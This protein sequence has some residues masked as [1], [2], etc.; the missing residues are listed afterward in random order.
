MVT[1]D[2][3]ILFVGYDHTLDWMIQSPVS[4]DTGDW[5]IQ[6]RSY[7]YNSVDSLALGVWILMIQSFVNLIPT[8]LSLYYKVSFDYISWE[9][10]TI[11][12]INKLLALRLWI[13][14]TQTLLLI[15]V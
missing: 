7:P 3:S 1:Q 14:I 9:I 12:S 11:S 15:P 13:F 5:I 2:T 8:K 6:S 4:E 10:G